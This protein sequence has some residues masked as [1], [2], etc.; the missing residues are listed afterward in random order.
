MYL[1]LIIIGSGFRFVHLDMRE[2]IIMIYQWGLVHIHPFEEQVLVNGFVCLVR[3][4][5]VAHRMANP[6]KKK[7][8]GVPMFC[9]WDLFKHI[10][11]LPTKSVVILPYHSTP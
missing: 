7:T 6:P 5:T 11:F 4:Q 9:I 10:S 3:T 8:F 2:T 1:G